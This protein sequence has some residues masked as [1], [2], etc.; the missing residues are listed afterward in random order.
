MS[1]RLQEPV[2]GKGGT[3]AG[4]MYETLPNGETLYDGLNVGRLPTILFTELDIKKFVMPGKI[5][6]GRIDHLSGT[7]QK[8]LTTLVLVA[9]FSLMLSI[10]IAALIAP[11]TSAPTSATVTPVLVTFGQTL[12]T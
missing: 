10:G 4:L 9:G 8:I 7:G 3:Y 6:K 5:W 12:L 2:P 1:Q 11:K